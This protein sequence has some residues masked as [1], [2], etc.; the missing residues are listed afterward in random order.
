MIRF[1][2]DGVII[3][4]KFDYVFFCY[5]LVIFLKRKIK[6]FTSYLTL[7]KSISNRICFK[8]KIKTKRQT[9]EASSVSKNNQACLNSMQ[10]NDTKAGMENIDKDKINAI[11]LKHSQS[12]VECFSIEQNII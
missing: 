10:I 2:L 8:I 3:Y 12:N 1:V 4:F 7:P 5:F 11:I 9:M 6:Y